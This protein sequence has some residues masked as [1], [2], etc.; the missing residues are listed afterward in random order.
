VCVA[1]P[2]RTCDTGR[3]VNQ[4]QMKRD[5]QV[6]EVSRI[7]RQAQTE[8][9][10]WE[11]HELPVLDYEATTEQYGDHVNDRDDVT[12]TS[13]MEPTIPGDELGPDLF[14]DSAKDKDLVSDGPSSCI[15]SL[16]AGRR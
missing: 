14:G 12:S 5:E 6:E 2:P 1:F 3:L 16:V 11:L 15:R 7:D 9:E 13:S 8:E 4:A 10:C